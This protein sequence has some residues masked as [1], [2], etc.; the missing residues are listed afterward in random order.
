MRL[1]SVKIKNFRLLKE[2][3]LVLEGQTTLVVGRN[4]SGKTSLSEVMRRFTSDKSA[5]FQIQDFSTEC[6][7]N[8][9]KALRARNVGEE[10]QEVRKLLPYIE[11]RMFFEYDP[12]QAQ[13]GA[14]GEFVIDLDMECREA[15]VVMR[16]ELTDGA[17][18][19]LFD[20]H[21]TEEWTDDKRITYFRSLGERIPK[22]Y[23]VN[24]WAEDPNDAENRK[25]SSQAAVK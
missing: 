3:E 25:V 24:V 1:H 16:F 9:C 23:T 2:V 15:L 4:N 13:F 12:T 10:E 19:R 7:D 20:G 5:A 18:D 22:L 6:H 11:L 14:L 8:F 21:S 17:I